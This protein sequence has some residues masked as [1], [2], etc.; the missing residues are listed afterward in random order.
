M[1]RRGLLRVLGCVPPCS[2]ATLP[3][4]QALGLG[5][6]P[7]L[8]GGRYSRAGIHCLRLRV[9]E[10]GC[11]ASHPPGKAAEGSPRS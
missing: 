6:L 9:S 2:E 3:A 5:V 1:E 4:E 11:S 10:P 7:M 8:R